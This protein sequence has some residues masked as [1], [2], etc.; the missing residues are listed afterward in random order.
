MSD[1]FNTAL[2]LS[3]LFGYF[4]E[5]KKLLDANDPRARKITNQIRET[6]ALLGLFKQDPATYLKKYEKTEQFPAEVVAIAEERKA[7]RLN[8]DWAKSDELRDKLKTLGY[9]VKDSKDGYTLSKI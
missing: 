2:A 1:D 9:A 6:Y 3:D 7:A 5:V 4:K 8:K